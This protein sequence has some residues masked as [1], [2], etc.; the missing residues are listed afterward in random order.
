MKSISLRVGN[1]AEIEQAFA[2]RER[3]DGMVLMSDPFLTVNS[4]FA[5]E[6]AL[7][8]FVSLLFLGFRK[9]APS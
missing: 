2:T 3:D 9:A 5:N 7:Q 1:S 6:K 4:A 8:F